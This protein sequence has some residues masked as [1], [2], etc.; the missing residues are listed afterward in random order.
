VTE[1]PVTSEDHVPDRCSRMIELRTIDL[2]VNVSTR[3]VRFVSV[4]V[5]P[6]RSCSAKSRIEIGQSHDTLTSSNSDWHND[7]VIDS[8][9]GIARVSMPSIPVRE[10]GDLRNRYKRIADGVLTRSSATAA[11]S[12]RRSVTITTTAL[13]FSILTVCPNIKVHARMRSIPFAAGC[14]TCW[15]HSTN[16]MLPSHLETCGT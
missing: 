11:Y 8:I 9:F 10:Q 2:R 7:L 13:P 4:Q 6:A 16:G 5:K 14:V 15:C 1:A 3:S 12:Q